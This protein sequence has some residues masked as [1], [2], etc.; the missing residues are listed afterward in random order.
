MDNKNK[1]ST[2]HPKYQGLVARRRA[3]AAV[4]GGTWSMR[5]AGK[6]VLRPFP[7]ERDYDARLQ[8]STIDGIVK[9]G[10]ESLTGAVFAGEI[11]TSGVVTALTQYLDNIDNR[12]NTFSVFA[13][14][15][16]EAAFDGCSVILA[17]MPMVDDEGR[18]IQAIYGAEA[19]RRLGLRPYLVLY[20]AADVINWRYRVNP[21]TKVTE[22][23]M[24]VVRVVSEEPD[25]DFG[26]A[27]V[28]RYS[29]WR[30]D[31]NRVVWERWEKAGEKDEYMIAATGTLANA[32]RIP[33]RVVGSLTDEPKLLVETDLE[34]KVFQKESS[35]DTVEHLQGSPTFYTKGY[36]GEDTLCVGADVHLKL[37]TDG[38]AGYVK[39]DAGGH[40]SLKATIDAIK[41]EIK[42]RL[43][44]TV[45]EAVA[46][47]TA[48][49]ANIEERDK[50]SRLVVWAEQLKDA[51]EG[52]LDD[53]AMLINAPQE[54]KIEMVS[55]WSLASERNLA[56]V[57]QN[58]INGIVALYSEGLISRETILAELERAGLLGEG[59]TAE[60]ELRRIESDEAAA[61]ERQPVMNAL[62]MPNGKVKRDETTGS[63]YQKNQAE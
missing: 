12:G 16:F 48:T 8:A 58:S 62:T 4:A 49:Q 34:I 32:T 45:T 63:Q 31:G 42:A 52:A 25:G 14:E 28:T 38:D 55:V 44:Y 50:Q 57:D 19:D 36:E 13:R 3:F 40:E 35:F 61:A 9:G 2:E 33:A 22:L 39:L 46:E 54:N 59:V 37:P 10:I 1:V 5:E 43:N 47:K 23:S 18:Q 11:N 17:D 27:M 53:M 24:L 60:E 21:V 26:T 56:S 51:L 6:A 30:L 41:A 15:A 20:R 7:Q 29:V